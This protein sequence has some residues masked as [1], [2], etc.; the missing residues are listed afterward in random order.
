[1][2]GFWWMI[3]YEGIVWWR[4]DFQRWCLVMKHEGGLDVW[5][6]LDHVDNRRECRRDGDE[7][8][9]MKDDG[10]WYRWCV[11]RRKKGKGGWVGVVDRFPLR[12]ILVLVLSDIFNCHYHMTSAYVYLVI[13][14]CFPGET[15]FEYGCFRRHEMSIFIATTHNMPSTSQYWWR[16]FRLFLDWHCIVG[17]ATPL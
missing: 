11:E 16:P 6:V 7:W 3:D 4:E 17:H 5:I 14:Q 1:M 13:V 9:M 15:R 10:W 12:D 8:W 2:I